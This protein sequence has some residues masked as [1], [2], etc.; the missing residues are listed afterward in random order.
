MFACPPEGFS[1]HAFWMMLVRLSGLL[2]DVGSALMPMSQVLPWNSAFKIFTD[3]PSLHSFAINAYSGHRY[4]EP[5]APSGN[6][7]HHRHVRDTRYGIVM[8]RSSPARTV[9]RESA[10][11]LRQ[12]VPCVGC[13]SPKL[14]PG[15]PQDRSSLQALP[16]SLM[17]ARKKDVLLLFRSIFVPDPVQ[18]WG[19]GFK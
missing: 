12:T 2:D 11:P 9:V 15:S 7:R 19:G 10:R 4:I 5:R 14:F 18:I 6:Y 8:A 1:S 17:R 13:I 3:D 16:D